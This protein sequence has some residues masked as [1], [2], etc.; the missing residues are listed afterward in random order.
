MSQRILDAY[1][2][3]FKDGSAFRP[4]KIEQPTPSL[5]EAQGTTRPVGDPRVSEE[6]NDDYSE[7]DSSMQKLVDAKKRKLMEKSGGVS[8]A[9]DNDLIKEIKSLKRRVKQL[10]NALSLVMETQTKLLGG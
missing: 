4:I 7:F 2:K 10:E 3:M 6:R 1:E 5:A 8:T 9:S